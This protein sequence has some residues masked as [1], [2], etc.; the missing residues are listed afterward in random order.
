MLMKRNGCCYTYIYPF[1]TKKI[2]LKLPDVKTKSEAKFVEVAILRACRTSNYETL[3]PISREACIR[4]FENQKWQLPEELGGNRAPKGELTVLDASKLFLKY[5]E[6]HDC[7]SRWRYESARIH[8]LVKL[9]TDTPV[10]SLWVPDLKQYQIERTNEKAAADT[11]NR[12]LSTLSKIF[13]VLIELQ[14]VEGN[15]VRLVKRLSDR[16]GQRQVYLGFQDVHSIKDRCPR[17]YQPMLLTA[18]YTGMKRGE[19]LGLTRKQVSLSRRMITLSPVDTKEVHWKRIPIHRDLVPVLQEA[20]KVHCFGEDRVFVLQNGDGVRSL[21]LET[22]KNVWPRVCEAMKLK[23]PLPRFHDL[24]H[25]WKTNA[26]RSGMDSEIR[27]SILGH[28]LRGKSVSERY[29]RIS[30]EELVRAIDMLTFDHGPTGIFVA[31]GRAE[32]SCGK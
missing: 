15:P 12:E 1:K 5:P 4:M 20:L 25:T 22:F 14:L 29:G 8:L 6:I 26:R 32:G 16:A 31:N 23:E 18:Y 2:G 28:S 24:R 30:N 7:P 11:V 9:G 10:K 19:I 3:D 27:E 17:W 21:E 13:N